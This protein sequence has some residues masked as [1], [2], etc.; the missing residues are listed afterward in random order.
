MWNTRVQLSITPLMTFT[1]WL[2]SRFFTK[3]SPSCFPQNHN[4]SLSLL[5]SLQLLITLWSLYG[6]HHQ[7]LSPS[8][9]HHQNQIF[10]TGWHIF[11]VF[12]ALKLIWQILMWFQFHR[13]T[14]TS[15][16]LL[17]DNWKL[18]FSL[19]PIFP[20]KKGISTAKGRL[21]TF[22][23]WCCIICVWTNVLYVYRHRYT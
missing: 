12:K 21:G 6:S 17:N 23:M 5:L 14:P 3:T 20:I 2:I 8:Q 22:D 7:K 13:I 10:L 4:W 9:P 16:F 11:D 18:S 1:L 19:R 15:L